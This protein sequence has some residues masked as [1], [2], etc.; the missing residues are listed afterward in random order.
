MTS[1]YHPICSSSSRD[2]SRSR[3][4]NSTAPRYGPEESLRNR[5]ANMKTEQRSGRSDQTIDIA[6]VG[7][8]PYGLSIAAH[9]NARAI[10]FR[11][12]GSP[13]SGWA[14]GMPCGMRLKSEGYASSLSD[15][16]SKFTLQDYCHQEEI[17][18]S[19]RGVRQAACSSKLTDCSGQQE[20]VEADHVH[21]CHRLSGR[22][23]PGC[24]PGC[25][26]LR[27]RP[28]QHRHCRRVSSHRFLACIL[29][30]SV[31]QIRSGL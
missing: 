22:P 2:R 9:L 19:A 28:G 4:R 15:P 25:E 11:I 3:S 24:V 5:G 16:E 31:R 7:A 6:I 30:E 23:R 1:R 29:S 20:R 26:A 8:G 18:Y 17:P 12:F 10:R 21:R 27:E 14:T 13:M